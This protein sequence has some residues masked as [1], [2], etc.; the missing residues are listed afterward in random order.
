MRKTVSGF[1]TLLLTLL[2]FA[3]LAFATAA[4]ASADNPQLGYCQATNDKREP[5]RFISAA[6][7][8]LVD[9]EGAYRQ[10]GINTEDIV[11]GFKVV[12]NQAGKNVRLTIDPQKTAKD[13]AD[14]TAADCPGVNRVLAAPNEPTYTPAV[15]SDLNNPYGRV[16]VPSD[17]GT[18][19]A[20]YTG[21]VLSADKTVYT[22]TYVLK[23]DSKTVYQWEDVM[24]ETKSYAFNVV[25]LTNDPLYVVD[26][27]TGEGQCELSNTGVGPSIKWEY[28]PLGAGMILLA[29]ILFTLKP[30]IG[31]R[32]SA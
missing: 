17:L 31:R 6:K 19:V 9:S 8:S 5:Y 21:P 1:L 28:I 11:P 4:P 30:T 23:E 24:G 26:G 7:T 3:A 25:N 14:F 2:G 29:A 15:C 10:G 18:G 13:E 32:F 27:K 12:V 20:S 16:S 22:V